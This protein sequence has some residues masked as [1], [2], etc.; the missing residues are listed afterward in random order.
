MQAPVA[1][2]A[3]AGPNGMMASVA[4]TDTIA[5]TGATAIIHG[6][7]VAGV[8]ASLDSSFNTSASGCISP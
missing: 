2:Q 8:K 5:I 7:A 3:P 4:I 1:A 6:I